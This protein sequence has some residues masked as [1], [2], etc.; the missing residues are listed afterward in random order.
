MILE[1]MLRT[2]D[3]HVFGEAYRIVVH[4]PIYFDGLHVQS[5]QHKI[6]SQFEKE[7]NLLLNEPRGHRGM[8]GCVVSASDVADYQLLFFHHQDAIDFKY[9][10]LLA[11]TTVLLEIGHIPTAE[12]DEYTV[13][14]AN[15][16][17]RV[18]AKME[19]NEVA[20]AKIEVAEGT[21]IERDGE[22]D[23][24]EL[25]SGHRFYI[26]PLPDTITTL[27]LPQLSEIMEWGAAEAKKLVAQHKTFDGVILKEQAAD[28]TY[29]SVT[30]E[31]DGY[32][33]RSPGIE[34]SVAMAAQ[35]H[36]TD[37]LGNQSIFDSTIMIRRVPGS[38]GIFSVE[39]VPYITGSHE[40]ILDPED[41]LPKGFV[42]V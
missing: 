40:F 14:T 37:S 33:L 8:N 24:V 5:N 28:K 2:L 21:I 38:K 12:N 16:V 13:E 26:Y 42:L 36:Q 41:P 30:F 7:K 31:R 9:E 35:E 23:V 4:S 18:Q 3:T 10:A 39:G 20:S 6:D 22:A 32:V 29:R 17:W 27:Q 11:T 19:E 34:S 1:K 25:A 15:G